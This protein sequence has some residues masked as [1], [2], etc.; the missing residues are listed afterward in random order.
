MILMILKCISL[1]NLVLSIICCM[2]GLQAKDIYDANHFVMRVSKAACFGGVGCAIVGTILP[3]LLNSD[4]P[5]KYCIMFILMQV[6]AIYMSAS[7]IPGMEQLEVDGDVIRK[8]KLFVIQKEWR[9]QDIDHFEGILTVEDKVP[10]KAIA[11]YLKEGNRKAFK[12]Y[13]GVKGYDLFC[14]RISEENIPILEQWDED[15]SPVSR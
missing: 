10:Q 2:K 13:C 14:Q 4:P 8:T 12:V 9:F 5:I 1:I 7:R 15:D 11:A 3:F 6:G